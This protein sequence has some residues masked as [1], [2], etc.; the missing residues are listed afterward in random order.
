[1]VLGSVVS[2]FEV[3]ATGEPKDEIEVVEMAVNAGNA[4]GDAL[5]DDNDKDDDETNNDDDEV[6]NQLTTTKIY[7]KF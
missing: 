3:V 6:M 1:M 4:C 2:C 7:Y 5:C